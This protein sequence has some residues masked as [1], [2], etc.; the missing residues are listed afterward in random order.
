MI[1]TAS[2]IKLKIVNT[3]GAVHSRALIKSP[4]GI[5]FMQGGLL[6]EI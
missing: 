3:A 6:D 1:H 4:G 2:E 5:P